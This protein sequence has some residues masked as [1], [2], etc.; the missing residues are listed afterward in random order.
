MQLLVS[1]TAMCIGARASHDRLDNAWCLSLDD[2]QAGTY[3]LEV[4]G[5]ARVA[6]AY[7]PRRA[8]DPTCQT[9]RCAIFKG[10]HGDGAAVKSARALI[11][12]K[13]DVVP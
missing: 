10:K 5:M 9:T 8:L 3:G 4:P 6:K 2:L 11:G 7:E 13:P 12:K 1:H